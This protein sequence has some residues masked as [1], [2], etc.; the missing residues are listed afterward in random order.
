[1][2]KETAYIIGKEP[3]N[4]E[5]IPKL[6]GLITYNLRNIPFDKNENIKENIWRLYAEIITKTLPK[7]TAKELIEDVLDPV[8]KD[9][10]N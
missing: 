9:F 2:T 6:C 1:M 4:N 10:N 5:T 8:F 7:K 3:N